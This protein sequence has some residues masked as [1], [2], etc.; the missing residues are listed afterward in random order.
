MDNNPPPKS[1][2]IAITQRPAGELFGRTFGIGLLALLGL[3]ILFLLISML[4]QP[5]SLMTVLWGVL[6]LLAVGIAGWVGY[7]TVALSSAK[8]AIIGAYLIIEWGSLREV[9]SLTDSSV[10]EGKRGIQQFRGVRWP[11]YFVGQ[12]QLESK[13][14]AIF[15][16]KPLDRQI[17]IET[18]EKFVSISPADAEAFTSTLEKAEHD[19]SIEVKAS[20]YGFV[21]LGVWQN[22]LVWG[23]LGIGLL[24]NVGLFSLLTL[25]LGRLANEIPLHFASS[26]EV[27]RWGNPAGLFIIPFISLVA[28]GF[29]SLLGSYFYHSRQEPPIAYLLW[30]TTIFVQLVAWA[31]IINLLA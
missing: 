8:Y 21:G 16:T 7:W 1:N 15:A 17:L 29:N 25:V 10:V 20:D 23:M 2:P 30:G 22:G 11:G 28:W 19:A 4:A 5:T 31:V 6:G 12:G 14:V 26:G 13:P 24:L 18:P 3:L 27:D 9:I